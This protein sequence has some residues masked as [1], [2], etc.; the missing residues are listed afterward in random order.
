MKTQ[1]HVAMYYGLMFKFSLIK[2][3]VYPNSILLT[4][5]SFQNKIPRSTFNPPTPLKKMKKKRIF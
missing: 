1:L 4:R 5:L 2:F 3:I